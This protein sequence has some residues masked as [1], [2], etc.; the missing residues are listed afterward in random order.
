MLIN[1]NTKKNDHFVNMEFTYIHKI[2]P[3]LECKQ[4]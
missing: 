3:V 4:C 1:M 2:R